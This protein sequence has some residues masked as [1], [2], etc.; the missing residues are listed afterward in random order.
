MRLRGSRKVPKK[1]KVGYVL[2]EFWKVIGWLDRESPRLFN[3]LRT[4]S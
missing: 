1:E 4:A 3:D 2:D